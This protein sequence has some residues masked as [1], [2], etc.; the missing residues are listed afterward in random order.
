MVV[1]WDNS[2]ALAALR[3][4]FGFDEG[5]DTLAPCDD[6]LRDV[7]VQEYVQDSGCV[8]FKISAVGDRYEVIAR[9][10]LTADL[11]AT[12]LGYFLFDSQD[13]KSDAVVEFDE[14]TATFTHSSA[15]MPSKQ[16]LDAICQSVRSELELEIVGIDV[17][18]DVRKSAFCIV[19]VNYFPSYRGIPCAPDWILENICTKAWNNSGGKGIIPSLPE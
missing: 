2:G 14:R 8:V 7:F 5:D 19:D 18:F 16:L 15:I 9:E 17:L 4:V 11:T 3:T 13:M 12:P 1:V 10:G 6:L